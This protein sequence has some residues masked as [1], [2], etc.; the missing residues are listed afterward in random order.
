MYLPVFTKA[1]HLKSTYPSRQIDLICNF[2]LLTSHIKWINAESQAETAPFPLISHLL[3]QELSLK[4]EDGLKKDS[5]S[6]MQAWECH[7]FSISEYSAA[8]QPIYP[9]DIPA[10]PLYMYAR[11]DPE[12]AIIM[13]HNVSLA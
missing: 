3:T 1:I 5:L 2:P 7:H 4:R 10:F 6:R 13:S 9:C 11:I 8:L 12:A